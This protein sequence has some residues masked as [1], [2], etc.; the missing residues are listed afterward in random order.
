[1]GELPSRPLRGLWVTFLTPH[2]LEVAITSAGAALDWIAVDLQ[3]GVLD[4][5][6]LPDLLRASV[7]PVLARVASHDAAHVGR[8]LDTGVLGIIVPGVESASQ[9]AEVVSAAYPPPRGRRSSG[10]SRAALLGREAD[11]LVVAMVETAAGLDRVAEIA[12]TPGIDGILVGPYDL[13]LSIGAVSVTATETV[14]AVS[15][16]LSA[17][18][19]KGCLTGLFAGSAEL[20]GRFHDVDLLAVDSDAAILR[21]GML[22]VFSLEGTGSGSCDGDRAQ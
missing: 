4:E 9:A 2:G 10:T 18:R 20:A 5:R 7:R 16:A 6:D 11:P 8:V 19:E 17:A 15:I 12:A 21:R 22:E 14:E 13:S 1:M 3:H